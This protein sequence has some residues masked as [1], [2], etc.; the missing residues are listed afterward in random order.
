M[1]LIDPIQPNHPFYSFTAETLD[2][3]VA[4]G[5]TDNPAKSSVLLVHGRDSRYVS[6][7]R[8]HRRSD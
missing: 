1:Q 5:Y 4:K 3:L 2:T 6:S 8:L 7:K